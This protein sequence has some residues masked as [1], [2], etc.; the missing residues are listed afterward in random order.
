MALSLSAQTATTKSLDA[1]GARR[2]PA[3]FS[4]KAA[5]LPTAGVADIHSAPDTVP[6]IEKE[7]VDAGIACALYVTAALITGRGTAG[8]KT[9]APQLACRGNN[10]KPLYLCAGEAFCRMRLNLAG[11]RP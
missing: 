1:N 7:K 11:T 5:W 9:I 6:Y 8:A 10:G 4:A 2:V 3:A